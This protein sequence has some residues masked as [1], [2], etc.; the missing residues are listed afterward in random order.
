MGC[1]ATALPRALWQLTD[2]KLLGEEVVVTLIGR[3]RHTRRG[4]TVHRVPD[5]GRRDMRRRHGL[6]VT[7][8][9]RTLVDLAAE[10]TRLELENAYAEARRRGLARDSE[11]RDA[12]GRAPANKAGVGRLRE[13]VAAAVHGV[14]PSLTRSH[15][16]RRLLALIRAAELPA[17][18]ANATV[19]GHMVDL[20][21]AEQRLIVEFDG[22]GTHGSRQLVRDRSSP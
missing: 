15:A 10:L 2:E 7:S 14:D 8:P 16:E 3:Q 19:A 22:F 13:L 18:A 12:L 6:P 11:I 1:S 17:P 5:L 4:L 21:W 20:L 9:A